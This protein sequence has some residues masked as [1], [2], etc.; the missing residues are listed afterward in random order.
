MKGVFSLIAATFATVV[1]TSAVLA[2]DVRMTFGIS[3]PPF[4]LADQDAGIEVDIAREALAFSGHTLVPVYV[5]PRRIAHELLNGY[6]DAAAKDQGIPIED[7]G[8]HYA[9]KAFFLHAAF[10]VLEDSEI[11]IQTPSDLD[12]LQVLAFQNASNHWPEWLQPVVQDGRYAEVVDQELQ[13]K[14][15]QR[16]RVDVIIADRAIFGYH[17]KQVREASDVP[18][19]S[20]KLI[21]FIEKSEGYAPIFRSAEI[22]DDFNAGLRHLIDTGRYDEIL[23]AYTQ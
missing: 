3:L 12:G 20:A 16:G 19:K 4:V 21:E 8:Y 11:D 5:P 10:F 2:E 18:L 6:V 9:D 7:D 13:V 14:M 15:L 1:G 22:R 23:A 17:F